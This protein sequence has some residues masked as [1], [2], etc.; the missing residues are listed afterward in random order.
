MS[1]PHQPLG[2]PHPEPAAASL[3]LT[4]MSLRPGLAQPPPETCPQSSC[5]S[6]KRDTTSLKSR[7]DQYIMQ[8]ELRELQKRND[9]SASRSVLT[10]EA[11]TGLPGVP[12][13]SRKTWQT[14]A[15]SPGSVPPWSP[16]KIPQ[17]GGFKGTAQEDG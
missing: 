5:W 3:T 16:I 15:P 2:F 9:S 11:S 13:G 12:F 6:G 4:D 8:P 14:R 10:A 1:L 7:C 17:W